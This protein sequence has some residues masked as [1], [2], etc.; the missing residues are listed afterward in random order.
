[1]FLYQFDMSTK[2]WVLVPEELMKILQHM[3]ITKQEVQTTKSD[4]EVIGALNTPKKSST[5]YFSD[6]L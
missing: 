6:I 5:R 3:K 4:A 1:M 2:P